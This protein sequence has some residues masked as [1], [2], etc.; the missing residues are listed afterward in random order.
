[1][2]DRWPSL[3]EDRFFGFNTSVTNH[4]SVIKPSAWAILG[5][6]R[7]LF[8]ELIMANRTKN[9]TRQDQTE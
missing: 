6:S 7:Q 1:M 9:N 5:S 2:K 8:Y 4:L 3:E